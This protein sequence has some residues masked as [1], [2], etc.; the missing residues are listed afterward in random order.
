MR[1]AV[2]SSSRRAL[3]LGVPGASS[4]QAVGRSGVVAPIALAQRGGGDA[5]GSAGGSASSHAAS[6]ATTRHSSLLPPTAAAAA[7]RAASTTAAAASVDAPP[8]DADAKARAVA[9]AGGKPS[10]VV[11]AATSIE[12]PTSDESEALLRIRHSVSVLGVAWRDG[13]RERRGWAVCARC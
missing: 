7:R 9:K 1:R 3:L 12:L 4:R 13:E 8:A 10:D 6:A 2:A 11:A 5:G